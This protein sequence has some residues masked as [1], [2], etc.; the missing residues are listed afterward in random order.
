MYSQNNVTIIEKW[1][2]IGQNYIE[3]S[4]QG[5]VQICAVRRICDRYDDMGLCGGL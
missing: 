1:G 2:R 4:D 3:Q 5:Y